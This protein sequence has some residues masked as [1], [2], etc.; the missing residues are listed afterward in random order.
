MWTS[1]TPRKFSRTGVNI[2]TPYDIGNAIVIVEISSLVLIGII[3]TSL[4][5]GLNL[6]QEAGDI[7]KS[8]SPGLLVKSQKLDATVDIKLSN[9]LELA[10]ILSKVIGDKLSDGTIRNLYTRCRMNLMADPKQDFSDS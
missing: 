4:I 6:S 10:F 1:R 3:G 5:F 2:S 7:Q 8:T 9:N